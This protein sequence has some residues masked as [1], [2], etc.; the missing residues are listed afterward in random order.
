MNKKFRLISIFITIFILIFLCSCN[1]FET[2]KTL[3]EN[4]KESTTISLVAVGDNLIHNTIFWAAKTNDGYDFTSIYS[5]VRNLIETADIAF[6]NQETPLASDIYPVS[7]YP[8]FNTPQKVGIDLLSV[9]FD[10]VNQATNHS[11]DKGSA[12]AMSTIQFWKKQRDA[13]MIGMYENEKDRDELKIIER[14][15]IKI[16]FLSYTYGTNGLAIPKDKPYLVSLIDKELIEKDI[17]NLKGQCDLIAVSMHWG[18]EYNMGV[19]DEQRQLAEYLT[20]QGADLIIGHHPHVIA[21]AQW[22]KSKNGNRAFCVYSLGNFL[23][24][25]D[26]RA[27]MLGGMLMAKIKKEDNKAIIE[28]AEI[29]PIVTHYEK[30]WKNY[31]I[32]SLYDYTD[33][34]A[35]KHYVNGSD[36]PIS[37]KYLKDTAKEIY[38]SFLAS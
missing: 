24:S 30:G 11:M 13:L 6:V 9:G 15:G 3:L 12:G 36:K 8:M 29:L 38:T 28:S 19:T 5:P 34:L 7:S 23:S 31:K 18:S 2:P 1:F 32:Y 35:K 37:V 17:S 20:E 14:N 10:V 22:I 25:Q 16:G 33:E 21:P 26:K 4:K 27:N